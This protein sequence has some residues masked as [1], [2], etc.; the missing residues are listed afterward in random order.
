MTLPSRDVLPPA[1]DSRAS[2]Y[3]RCFSCGIW[4]WPGPA[5]DV[6]AGSGVGAGVPSGAGVPYAD[7][8]WVT[9]TDWGWSEG[10]SAAAAA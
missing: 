2:A 5:A 8:G 9:A 10:G 6:G 7:V 3:N 4:P 1:S